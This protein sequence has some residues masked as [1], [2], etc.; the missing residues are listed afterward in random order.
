MNTNALIELY[1]LLTSDLS[2]E[3]SVKPQ[4]AGWNPPKDLPQN[5]KIIELSE[6]GDGG[7]YKS[8]NGLLVALSCCIE[9]DGKNWVHL[10]VSRK[11]ELPS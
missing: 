5:W 11:K 1:D 3:V 8:R 9:S 4:T 6:S 10:S 7:F 2:Q